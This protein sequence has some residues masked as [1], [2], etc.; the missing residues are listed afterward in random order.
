M[1]GIIVA[2]L[3][4]DICNTDPSIVDCDHS[5]SSIDLLPK[6]ASPKWLLKQEN[7]VYKRQSLSKGNILESFGVMQVVHK[8][9]R[10]SIYNVVY[11]QHLKRYYI[12]Y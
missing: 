1:N 7:P 3:F 10:K 5:E 8:L 9:L 6:T 12:L 4:Q 2:L 11:A